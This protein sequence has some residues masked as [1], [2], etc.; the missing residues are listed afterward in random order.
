MTGLDT[1]QGNVRVINNNN[2]MAKPFQTE[3][4][5]AGGVPPSY[6]SV[7]NVRLRNM[8]KH[9]SCTATNRVRG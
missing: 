9:W 2:I 6:K 7:R 3:Q 5:C 4:R 1:R 8:C